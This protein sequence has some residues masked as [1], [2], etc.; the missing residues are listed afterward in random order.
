MAV[1]FIKGYAAGFN[2]LCREITRL[3]P[4]GFLQHFKG[5]GGPFDWATRIWQRRETLES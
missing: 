3:Q 4:F 5:R 2:D 1:V